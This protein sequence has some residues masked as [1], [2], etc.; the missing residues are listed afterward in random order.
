M[1]GHGVYLYWMSIREEGNLGKCTG[2]GKLGGDAETV[3]SWE[4]VI[5]NGLVNSVF[6]NFKIYNRLLSDCSVCLCVVPKQ[7]PWN[8]DSENCADVVAR[9]QHR[10]QPVGGIQ[11]RSLTAGRTIYRRRKFA[12]RHW[13]RKW[14]ANF[15]H[16]RHFVKLHIFLACNTCVLCLN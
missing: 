4:H 16:F 13:R 2:G 5:S 12:Y 1:Y 6:R 3:K 15:C 8:N 10:C 14:K 11:S 7:T 9:E